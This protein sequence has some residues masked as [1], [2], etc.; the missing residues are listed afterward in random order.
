MKVPFLDLKKQQKQIEAE[1]EQAIKK[2]EKRSDFILGEDVGSFEREFAAYCGTSLAVGVNSGTDALFLSL[3]AMGIGPGDEV[4][5]PDFTFIATANA[6]SYTG[7]K[8]VFADIDGKTYN[9]DPQKIRKAITRRTKAIIPVHLFGQCAD[10]GPVMSIAGKY[11]LKV[12]EDACQAHGALYKPRAGKAGSIGDAGCFSFYPTKN[13]GGFG[14]GGL[15]VTDNLKLYDKLKVL[16]D[17][18]RNP[19]SRYEH[20]TVGYNS[21]LDTVQAAVLRVKLKYLDQWNRMRRY[22]AGLYDKLLAGE[23]NIIKPRVAEYSEHVYHIYAVRVK[24]RDDLAELL[25]AKGI[26]AMVNYPIP[27]HRQPAYKGL[28]YR[29]GDFPVAEKVCREI[30]SLPMHPL[31]AKEEIKYVADVLIKSTEV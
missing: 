7:A 24:N 8:P 29:K 17:C 11:G 3:V 30:I 28:G 25:R 21:R 26:G 4:I 15:V 9:I 13:L 6:V 14:D 27:L 31:L 2:V 20:S 18:G 5:V 22:N 16:R 19:K 23:L 10:M 1:I 12:I